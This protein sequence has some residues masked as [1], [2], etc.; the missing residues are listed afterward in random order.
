MTQSNWFNLDMESALFPVSPAEEPD[1][2]FAEG[3]ILLG[4][5]A[6]P[7]ETAL[8]AALAEVVE[9]APFRHMTTPGGHEMSV[10]MTNCG[11]VGWVTDRTGYRYTRHD[12]VSG[13]H[14][15]GMPA[16]FYELAVSAAAKAGYGGFAPD[17]CLIN[18]YAPGAKMG[19]HQDKDEPDLLAP[20]VSVSLGIPATFQFGGMRRADPAQ[21]LT[22]RHGDVAVWGGPSRLFYHGVLTLK[23]GHHPRLGACRINLTFRKTV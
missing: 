4:G 20:I 17:A 9:A 23:E 14:W 8:L 21:R 18:R 7:V 6:L 22:L 11:E 3:A 12:P 2:V 19:L 13:R 15:P 10:A 5:F 1:K 16:V